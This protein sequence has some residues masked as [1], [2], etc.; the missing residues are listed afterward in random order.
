MSSSTKRSFGTILL[1]IALGLMF[2]VG[3]IWTLQNNNGDEIAH[4][5]NDVFNGNIA[6]VLCIVMGVIEIICG[7]FLLLR[8]F[9]NM[10]TNIDSILMLI[11]MI[12][13]IVIIVLADVLGSQGII[14]V[15]GN[16]KDFLAFLNRF[17]RHLIILGAIIKVRS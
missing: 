8:L 17:A 5:I 6:N 3:G 13:W 12:C 9:V 2:V 7:V 16:G 11:I 14:K 15:I 4:A 10:S 1:Q